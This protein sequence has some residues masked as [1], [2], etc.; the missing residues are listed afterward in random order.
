MESDWDFF[1]LLVDNRPASI[2]VDLALAARAPIRAQPHM[3]YVLVYMR[4]PNAEG[5][6]SA[7]EF[8]MLVAIEDAVEAAVCG[9]GSTTYAGRNTCNGARDLYFYTSDPDGFAA[10]A[11]QAMRRFPDYQFDVGSQP[12]PAWETYRDFLYPSPAD[13]QRMLNRR[14]VTQLQSHGDQTGEPREIDHFAYLPDEPTARAM[15]AEL[16]EQ[17]F[18]VDPLQRREQDVAIQFHRHDSPDAIDD[19]VVPIALRIRE[20]GGEYDGWGCAVVP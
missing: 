2:A 17:G 13:G 4:Q 20:L 1:F 18:A 6:T 15:C 8:D 16:T 14:V 19:V 7:E 9:A 10:A 11:T 12:D 3:A 5:L